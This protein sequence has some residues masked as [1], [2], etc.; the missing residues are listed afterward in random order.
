MWTVTLPNGETITGP[1]MTTTRDE[2]GPL[3]LIQQPGQPWR[4]HRTRAD[5]ITADWNDDT[6]EGT[7]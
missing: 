1:S 3:V 6:Q 7:P 2:H 5:Q 4:Y